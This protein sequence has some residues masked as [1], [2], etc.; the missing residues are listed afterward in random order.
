MTYIP[1]SGSGGGSI[2]TSSDVALNNAA[3]KDVLTFDAAL[4]KWKNAP[5]AAA[6]FPLG[7]ANNPVTDANAVRPN[8]GAG[9]AVWWLTD[10]TPVNMV[11]GDIRISTV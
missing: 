2:S 8:L 6:A 9:I 10:T 4:A 1:G 5:V 11:N 7:S 3:D